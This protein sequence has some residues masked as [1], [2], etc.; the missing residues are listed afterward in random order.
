MTQAAPSSRSSRLR[1]PPLLLLLAGFWLTFVATS[2][3]GFE[4]S[5]AELRLATASSWLAGRGGAIDSPALTAQTPDGR[6]FS[7]YGPLQSVVMVPSL[8]VAKLLPVSEATRDNAARF[9]ITL[10][11]QPLLSVLALAFCFGALRHLGVSSTASGKATVAVGLGTL[12]W[13]YA[14]MGQEENLVALGFSLWLYGVSRYLK[15]DEWGLPWAALGGCVAI[16]TRW[17]AAPSLAVMALLTV[18]LMVR[19]GWARGKVL[20]LSAAICGG[21]L[22]GLF[23]Y[24]FHRF[25]HPLETGYGLY[26]K[27]KQLAFFVPERWAEQAAALLVS[28]YRGFFLY[29]PLLAAVLVWAFVRAR[30]V[31]FRGPTAPLSVLALLVLAVNVVFLSSYSFWD[32][33]FGWGPRF[34]AATVI[35]FA[36]MLGLMFERVRWGNVALGLA[37]ATQLLSVTLPATTENHARAAVVSTGSRTCTSWTCDCTAICLRPGMSLDALRNTLTGR[38]GR[39]I[40]PR[41]SLAPDQVLL[42]SDYQ[43]LNWWPVRLSFRMHL[44][45]R[46]VALA[47]SGTLLVLTALLMWQAFRQWQRARAPHEGGELS[48]A[49][50]LPPSGH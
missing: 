2:S 29:S 26:F 49:A 7:F 28:P 25:G 45:H 4:S 24:N 21:T 1:I 47:L 8:A 35:L 34:L 20:A 41:E 13:H 40:A 10:V 18:V 39:L 48:L 37:V 42:S 43:T 5:D 6:R 17:A 11:T 31:V 12:F 9:L 22:G 50:D 16:A 44:M 33:G 15:K 32:G 19:N 27:D 38:P 14:R 36:P 23:A 46:F 3:G 30:A